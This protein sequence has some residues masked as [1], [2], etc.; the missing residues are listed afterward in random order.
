MLRLVL[1]GQ[2]LLLAVLF[3]LPY[4]LLVISSSQA[5]EASKPDPYSTY[6]LEEVCRG[7]DGVVP[8]YLPAWSAAII[9]FGQAEDADYYG[10]D[11]HT[12]T[13][14]VSTEK[15][16]HLG[17]VVE[18]IRIQG[19]QDHATKRWDCSDYIV[20]RTKGRGLVNQVLDMLLPDKLFKGRQSEKL[21]GERVLDT[22]KIFRLVDTSSHSNVF[23]TMANSLELVYHQDEDNKTPVNNSFTVVISTFRNINEHECAAED[24][25]MC[26]G[27]GNVRGKELY[28]V[29]GRYRCD[30][31]VNCALPGGG[32]DERGCPGEE[33]AGLAQYSAVF[34]STIIIVTLL[35]GIIG[36]IILLFIIYVLVAKA[37]NDSNRASP[38]E[39][40]TAVNFA[41]SSESAD[42]VATSHRSRRHR[43]RAHRSGR[44]HDSI[45][46]EHEDDERHQHQQE[47]RAHNARG[48]THRTRRVEADVRGSG[49]RRQN[50]LPGYDAVT[51]NNQLQQQQD[52]KSQQQQQPLVG[53]N[54]YNS[55]NRSN[56][57]NLGSHLNPT[58]PDIQPYPPSYDILFPTDG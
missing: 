45:T 44:R 48:R 46:E 51:L 21:C 54:Q 9:T 17:G 41:A 14:K 7:V 30:G 13:L 35:G 16:F 4:F 55:F 18:N 3:T 27:G 58:A 43:H 25:V 5:D 40:T 33:V 1:G 50:T 31:H 8:V 28:C 39:S 38:A 37:R 11:R 20:F 12:C 26:S 15:N 10:R 49:P 57:Q 19:T 29:H 34:S 6:V 2:Q 36:G 22:S 52:E 24:Q 23:S 32:N 42:V 53:V 47:R 56:S